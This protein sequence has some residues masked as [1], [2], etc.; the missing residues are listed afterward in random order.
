VA[1]DLGTTL[2]GVGEVALARHDVNPAATDRLYPALHARRVRLA[3]RLVDAAVDSIGAAV[4]LFMLVGFTKR[5]RP[6][7]D[8]LLE[9]PMLEP[10]TNSVAIER[11][12]PLDRVAQQNH[13]P[14]LWQRCL[15]TRQ[16]V[17]V[18]EIA[19]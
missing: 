9:R 1:E 5:R 12:H 7:A 15:D 14:G 10:D 17:G 6:R 11:P 3:E 19:G 8:Q 4:G 13:E 2:V 16:G 18:K